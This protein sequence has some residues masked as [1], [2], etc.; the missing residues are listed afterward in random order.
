MEN[1]DQPGKFGREGCVQ[2]LKKSQI[3]AVL[4][5]RRAEAAI[6]PAAKGFLFYP[7]ADQVCTKSTSDRTK[8]LCR[9]FYFWILV[10]TLR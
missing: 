5:L 8:L 1:I 2:I 7:L 10:L 3:V 4:L 9:I 6:I